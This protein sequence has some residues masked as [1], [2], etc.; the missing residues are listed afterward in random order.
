MG[1]KISQELM[2]TFLKD[3]Q[4]NIELMEKANTP[5]TAPKWDEILQKTSDNTFPKI[6]GGRKRRRPVYW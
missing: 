5:I 4:T 3:F 2:E 1:W 6:K